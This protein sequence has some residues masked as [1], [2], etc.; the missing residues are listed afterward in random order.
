LNAPAYSHFISASPFLEVP[1]VQIFISPNVL[2]LSGPQAIR[3]CGHGCL[4]NVSHGSNVITKSA[5]PDKTVKGQVI[6]KNA[7]LWSPPLASNRNTTIRNRI[8]TALKATSNPA[9]LRLC[10]MLISPY[11]FRSWLIVYIKKVKKSQAVHPPLHN[12]CASTI[13]LIFFLSFEW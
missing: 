10:I 11:S 9:C 5:I 4:L 1:G 6:K 2:I 8:D 13:S 7:E 12:R 3:S